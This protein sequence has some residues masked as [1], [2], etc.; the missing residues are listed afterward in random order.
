M[1]DLSTA[2]RQAY[3]RSDTD[4]R[5]LLAL[6]ILHAEMPGGA[7]RYVNHDYDINVGGNLHVGLA[8]S[9]KEPEIGS[10]PDNKV[11]VRIDGTP[12][13]MQ[14]YINKAIKTDVVEGGTIQANI[15]PF[16]FNMQSRSV[17]DVVGTFNFL[18]TAAEYDMEAVVLT[19]GHVA[20]TNLT[21]PNR[22]Y[23]PLEYKYLYR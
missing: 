17:I 15:R 8:M 12:G 22:R 1:G 3:A 23:S 6:E 7:L 4:T 13:I 18:V 10:E 16:A 9:L 14:F 19:L 11:K 5:H 21:F 20:P 2:L